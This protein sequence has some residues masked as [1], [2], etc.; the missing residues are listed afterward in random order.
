MAHGTS[1]QSDWPEGVRLLLGVGAQKAGTTWIYHYLRNHPACRSAPMK[2]LHYF[3][4]I[5]DLPNV[6]KRKRAQREKA[7][8]QSGRN[9]KL[10]QGIRRLSAICKNPDDNHHSYVDLLVGGLR[11]GQVAMDITPCYSLLDAASFRQM[12]DLG[13]TRFLFLIREP[14][15]RLWSA[16]RMK[17]AKTNADPSCFETDCQQGL[18]R[19]LEQGRSEIV[20]R[21][22]YAGTLARLE[23]AVPSSRRLVMFYENLFTQEA[24]DRICDF[25]EIARYPLGEPEVVNEG[26]RAKM[27]ADQVETLVAR[28]RP[29]Y[30]AVRA[31]FGDEIP[32]E[33]HARFAARDP[34]AVA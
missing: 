2:E 28:L 31:I 19:V 17:T 10:L 12:A 24:A 16:L 9:P 18:D 30:E 29:Q 33:W 26:V 14:V 13:D 23:E 7:L 3:N 34:R 6:G 1:H 4:E 25:L 11:P 27:R 8:A 22:D 20:A 32:Q 5:A 21:S 15:S